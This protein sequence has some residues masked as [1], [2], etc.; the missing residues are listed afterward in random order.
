MVGGRYVGHDHRVELGVGRV[1]VPREQRHEGHGD[2]REI[3]RQL[4]LR[5]DLQ[6]T[7]RPPRVESKQRS[8]EVACH[9]T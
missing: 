1:R 9:G 5:T 6:K 2:Q 4:D 3:E 7:E 8:D